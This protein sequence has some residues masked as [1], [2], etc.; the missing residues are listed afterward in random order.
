MACTL[1]GSTSIGCADSNGGVAEIKVKVFNSALTGITESSGTVTMAGA[2]LTGWYTYQ[3]EKQTANVV[4]DL[5]K[6]IQNGTVVYNQTVTYIFNKLQAS[7]RNELKVL[8]QNR[9]HIAVKDN[10]GTAWLFGYERGMDLTGANSASGTNYED[11]SGYTLT[12]TGME[13]QPT[14]TISNYNSLVTA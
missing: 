5:V 2:A 9:M 6:N 12:F 11:R 13:A 14:P 8:G 4:E 10:N 7:F 3:C 1:I